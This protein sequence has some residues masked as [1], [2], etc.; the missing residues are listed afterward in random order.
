MKELKTRF[1][2]SVKKGTKK[3]FK[4]LKLERSNKKKSFK[5]FKRLSRREKRK[6]SQT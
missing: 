2:L 6:N 1:F 4:R 5:R 3:Y